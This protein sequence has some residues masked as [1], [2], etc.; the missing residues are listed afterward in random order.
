MTTMPMEL[1]VLEVILTITI[2]TT[3]TVK[4]MMMKNTMKKVTRKQKQTNNIRSGSK[5]ASMASRRTSN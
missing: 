2:M 1:E 5:R 3:T 4:M